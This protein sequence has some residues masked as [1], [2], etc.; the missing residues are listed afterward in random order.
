MRVASFELF[1][2]LIRGIV[3]ERELLPLNSSSGQI[4][5]STIWGDLDVG[6][7]YGI[8]GLKFSCGTQNDVYNRLDE[9][10][11]RTR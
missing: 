3:C 8:N 4:Q 10:F 2:A 9:A 1:I 5:S 11:H 7:V 6:I